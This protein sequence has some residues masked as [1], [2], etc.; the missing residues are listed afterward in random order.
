MQQSFKILSNKFIASSELF[1]V[2]FPVRTFPIFIKLALHQENKPR[3]SSCQKEKKYEKSFSNNS[4]FIN[5]AALWIRVFSNNFHLFPLQFSFKHFPCPFTFLSIVPYLKIVHI[6]TRNKYYGSQIVVEF[7]NHENYFVL[8]INLIALYVYLKRILVYFL[9]FLDKSLIRHS[10]GIFYIIFIL[11]N[12][13]KDYYH[14]KISMVAYFQC[15]LGR[16]GHEYIQVGTRAHRHHNIKATL[17]FYWWQ[18]LL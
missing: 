9:I 5:Q 4:L 7:C 13:I 8:L 17:P 3:Q 18:D 15:C 14:Q 6:S 16:R 12:N 1:A 10:H 11:R 2:R